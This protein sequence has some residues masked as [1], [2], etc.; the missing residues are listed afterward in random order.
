MTRKV[1]KLSLLHSFFF[2]NALWSSRNTI[3]SVCLCICAASAHHSLY[4]IFIIMAWDAVLALNPIALN[5]PK[6]VQQLKHP[7]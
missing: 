6:H 7:V 3:S 4:F 2:G 1:Y 5:Y